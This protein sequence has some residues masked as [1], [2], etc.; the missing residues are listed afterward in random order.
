MTELIENPSI[1][2]AQYIK[3]DLKL[4][5]DEITYIPLEVISDILF[6]TFK[7]EELEKII[8]HLRTFINHKNETAS[9]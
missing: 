3:S 1:Q 8:E 2:L 9:A 7:E 4:S 5:R 6:T